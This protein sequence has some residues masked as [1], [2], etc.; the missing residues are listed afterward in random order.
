LAFGDENRCLRSRAADL[1]TVEGVATDYRFGMNTL[2]I[3]IDRGAWC[4]VRAKTLE[5][6][7]I[8]IAASAPAEN[9]AGQQRFS[10]QCDEALGIEVPWMQRPEPHLRRLTLH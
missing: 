5:L 10:P 8:P 6:W 4:W 7:M 1:A 3:G 2:Q 9:G